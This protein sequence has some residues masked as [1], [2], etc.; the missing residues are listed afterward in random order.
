MARSKLVERFKA[1]FNSS[2]TNR[3]VYN[4]RRVELLEVLGKVQRILD[5]RGSGF[6]VEG[7]LVEQEQELDRLQKRLLELDKLAKTDP[8]EAI[9][10]LTELEDPSD[11]LLASAQRARRSAEQAEQLRQNLLVQYEYFEGQAR[12][13][14]V[15]VAEYLGGPSPKGMHDQLDQ[16]AQQKGVDLADAVKRLEAVASTLARLANAV[17]TL[18]TMTIPDELHKDRIEGAQEARARA[19]AGLLDASPEAAWDGIGE[20]DGLLKS[21]DRVLEAQREVSGTQPEDTYA[22]LKLRMEDVL[23]YPAGQASE[24]L[25]ELQKAVQKAK[26]AYE[27]AAEPRAKLAA[28]LE[29]HDVEVDAA[30]PRL[31]LEASL[32]LPELKKAVEA[33]R[34][35]IDKA[36]GPLREHDAE[37]RRYYKRLK[38]LKTRIA[39]ADALP[40]QVL[41]IDTAWKA[42]KEAYVLAKAAV[43]AEVDAPKRDY[44]AGNLA[45]DELVEKLNALAKKRV[46][47]LDAEVDTV[48][49]GPNGSAKKSKR[50]VDELLNTPGLIAEMKPEQQLK[51]LETLR[52]KL[53]TCTSC[54]VSMSWDEFKGNGQKCTSCN[55]RANIDAP[56]V[57]STCGKPGKPTTSAPCPPPCGGDGWMY[58]TSMRTHSGV[59]AHPNRPLLEALAKVLS[60][61]KLDPAFVEFDKDKRKEIVKAVRGDP[62]FKE[63]E[64][65]ENGWSKWVRDGDTVKMEA[66][67]NSVLKK[68]WEVLAPGL[69][70]LTRQMGGT[71]HQFPDF[72]VKVKFFNDPDPDLF[73]QCSPG[74]PTWI[75]INLN[76]EYIGDFKEQVDTIIHENMHAFQEMLISGLKKRGP[77]SDGSKRTEILNNPQLAIQAQMFAENDET[78]INSDTLEY[79]HNAKLLSSRAYRH[80]PLEEHAWT[81]GGKSSQA[82]LVPPQVRSFQSKRSMKDKLFFIE[83]IERANLPK[84][85]LRERHGIYSGEWEGERAG[86]KRLILEGV[87]RSKALVAIPASIEEVVDE[88]TLQL[89]V[90]LSG[91]DALVNVT[92]NQKDGFV[93]TPD[94]S[95]VAIVS[96][97]LVLDETVTDL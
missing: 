39:M 7:T 93:E 9:G 72:P 82:L 55:S 8:A 97:R 16:L 1:V 33:L 85:R 47:A 65:R 58:A 96:A 21:G 48:T 22:R 5:A 71:T 30:P 94:D 70:N 13:D 67:L 19:I 83:W 57:C 49:T 53:I 66:F 18:K 52:T 31:R 60:S 95:K 88:F 43:K 74:F 51:L 15:T 34:E 32:S 26:L 35:A 86:D 20:L 45:L 90:D 89:D 42:E 91:Y 24:A 59:F 12:T 6:L 80:E 10:E 29:K 25:V 36:A 64:D 40:L 2:S 28:F 75:E 37:L 92:G 41:G 81:T 79:S 17:E 61:M 23:D 77:F 69:K 3:S 4:E 27:K 14:L 76:G 54:D 11:E 50:L 63:A 56:R 38:E 78:Y 68:Q 46:D 44:K 84:V 73:G 87:K 62:S